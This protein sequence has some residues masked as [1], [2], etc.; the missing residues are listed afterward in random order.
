MDT[1]PYEPLRREASLLARQVSEREA[2]KLEAQ[3]FRDRTD[4]VRELK[5]LGKPIR[6]KG[7][8]LKRRV[9]RD[10]FFEVCRAEFGVERRST[11]HWRPATQALTKVIL[12]KK[13]ADLMGEL[14]NPDSSLLFKRK[15]YPDA[16]DSVVKHVQRFQDM[17]MPSSIG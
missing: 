10:L 6:P 5:D 9:T 12:R 8:L 14:F 2:R 3:R 7:V 13:V 4:V 11:P 17:M 15:S 16:Q 1:L